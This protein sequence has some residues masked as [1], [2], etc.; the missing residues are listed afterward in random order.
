MIDLSLVIE[1]FFSSVG[2]DP[3]FLIVAFLVLHAIFGSLFY[4]FFAPYRNR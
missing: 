1:D 4:V 3:I 2:N